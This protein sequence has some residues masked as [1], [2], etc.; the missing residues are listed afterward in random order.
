MM[1]AC[2]EHHDKAYQAIDQMMMKMEEGQRSNDASKMRA[3]LEDTQNRLAASKQ[4]KAPCMNMNDHDG[5]DGW[6]HRR[7]Y[8]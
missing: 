1:G 7:P 2:R 6:W 3:T 4:D 5:E 8:G